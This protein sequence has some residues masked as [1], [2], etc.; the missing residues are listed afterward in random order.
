MRG[1]VRRRRHPLDGRRPHRLRDRLPAP[2]LEVPPRHRR[3]LRPAAGPDHRRQQAQDPL[4]Q[5]ASTSTA[6]PI[7][8][9]RRA[10]PRRPVERPAREHRLRR[11]YQA[12]D[13][14]EIAA[15][16]PAAARVLRD[17]LLRG[18]RADRAQAAGPPA[19]ARARPPT[20]C[21]SSPQRWDAAGFDPRSIR[22]A[23]RPLAGAVLHGRRHPQEHRRPPAV[24]RLPGR[25]A[26]RPRCA[27]R[28]GCTCPA[29]RPASRGP[30]STPSGTARSAPCSWPEAF[31]RRG[32]GPA[33]WCSN[34]WSYGTHNG[35]VRFDEALYR[36]LN[37]VVLTTS[38]GNVT[39]TEKQ[40]EL[41]IQ[42][43]ATAILTTGDYLLRLAEV[44][45][46]TRL[47][48]R[49]RPED[50]GAAEH[51]RPR[52]C[53]R[54][55]SAPS[56]TAPTGSTRCSGS[57]VE[58]PARD[59]LHVYEDAFVV[60]IVDPETG[61]QLPD[62]QLGSI[63]HHRAVQDRQPA[64]P[65]QHHGPV[66]PATRASSAPAAAG[67]GASAP[68]AGRGD[69]MVK[70]RG[71]NVWPEAVGELA[72]SSTASTTDYF[73]RAVR[74]GNRD[75]MRLSVVGDGDP[76]GIPGARRRGR[77]TARRHAG[78]GD[79]R[80]GGAAGRAGRAHRDRDTAETQ[81][82]QGRTRVSAAGGSSTTC[83]TASC[84]TARRSGTAPSSAPGCRSRCAR[85]MRHVRRARRDGGAHGRARH[86]DACCCRRV[87]SAR[88]ARSI[89]L[90]TST[91]RRTGTRWR[92]WRPSSPGRFAALAV[93]K[94]GLG[95]GRRC[96]RC[97]AA[98]ARAVG[99]RACSPTPTAGTCVSTH[100]DYY[101]YYALASDAGRARSSCRR[102]RPAA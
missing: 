69:N 26:R 41:A 94:P 19:G 64:V 65:L 25:H 51:G 91:S 16:V 63:C 31:T 3:V 1:P 57:P 17:G 21:R 58:C 60:Q 6:S 61:E 100:A 24:R 50:H 7:R 28:C 81:A 78:R 14:D 86:R 66:L 79:R 45:R 96:A 12:V 20:R 84:P 75:E 62:G 9:C 73:V 74:E 23:R 77:T 97:A 95:H 8:T 92:S 13:Y 68:F 4:G 59:G 15:A 88:T 80:A 56:T 11:P 27:S 49:Q 85:A 46:E 48:R 36:W 47:R 37:C 30:P 71:I 33:T 43:G 76:A 53:S 90:T 54:R 101:P 32:S 40:V 99:G 87:T 72:C 29:G 44:A 35:A 38:T 22:S 55:R 67:C 102:A 18:P 5:R 83:R 82:V 34:S 42:Y 2:R 10:S 89:P 39:A 93:P 52:R 98:L 70:L